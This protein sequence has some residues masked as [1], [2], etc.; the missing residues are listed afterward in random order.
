MTSIQILKS[1]S[2]FM[3]EKQK[4]IAGAVVIVDKKI[5]GLY[6]GEV[7][8]RFLALQPK[9]SDFGEQT[10]V[11]GFIESHS[12]MF[13]SALV[14]NQKITL[15]SGNSE[16]AC[17]ADLSSKVTRN[18][19]KPHQWIV[20]KGWYVPAWQEKRLPSRLTL[21]H[22]FPDNPVAIIADDLHTLWLNTAALD[23]LLPL[24]NPNRFDRDVTVTARG[25]PSGVVGEQT[26][27]AFLHRIFDYS[28]SQKAAILAPYLVHLTSLGL[29]STCDLAL[30]PAQTINGLDDQIYPA[31][32]HELAHQNRLPLRVHL[33]PYFKRGVAAL[34]KLAANYTTS[35]IRIA[36]GK[37]FFDGVTSSY[38]AWMKAPYEG[39]KMMGMPM[40]PAAEMKK[41]IFLAQQSGIPLRIHAI[42]DQAIHEALI[43][44]I[45][46]ERQFKNPGL[47]QHCLEH[48]ETI[49]PVDLPLMTKSGVIASVQPSH[50]LLDYQTADLYVGERSQTMWPFRSF[51]HHHISMAFG[52]DSPVVTDITP[53]DNLYFAM[54]RQT[55]AG[56]PPTGWHSNQRLTLV[57]ALA[58]QTIG[59]ARACGYADQIGSL[60]VG[61]LADIAVLDRNI[62]KTPVQEIKDIQISGT[63]VD[64]NWEYRKQPVNNKMKV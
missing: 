44:F 27:M 36:G 54:T 55:L 30:L 62:E 53:M 34:K 5:A 31:V 61:K 58:A 1:R 10:I 43:D 22:Y 29:T 49:D 32:Y 40:I 25:D 42:G 2:I 46:A 47:V 59:A 9:I 37:L 11:P 20:A 14:Y 17:A 48:L 33:Y 6:S 21:D 12:H 56:D 45:A 8:T 50:P 60:T 26:A 16:A 39:R 15:I 19:L 23:I 24:V 38:T 3:A 35:R 51:D 28:N 57:Q 64:G 7:P 13:L 52:T 41:L 63:M 4:F 18:R